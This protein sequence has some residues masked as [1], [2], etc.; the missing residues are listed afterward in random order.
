MQTVQTRPQLDY[1]DFQTPFPKPKAR[2]GGYRPGAGRP[3]GS[4][5]RKTVERE[6]RQKATHEL[7]LEHVLYKE[8]VSYLDKHGNVRTKHRERLLLILDALFARA[9]TGDIQ[10]IRVY[11]DRTIGKPGYMAGHYSSE[12]AA[13]RAST[14]EPVT[15]H[16]PPTKAELAAM[17]AYREALAEEEA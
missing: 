15:E 13:A 2:H 5:S 3:K 7:L 9:V 17:K 14:E 1:L 11:L 16:R 8:K 6:L 10:A 4:Q 12:R